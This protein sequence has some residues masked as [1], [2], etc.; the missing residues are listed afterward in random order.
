MGIAQFFVF[1]GHNQDFCPHPTVLRETKA[2]MW[3]FL[4]NLYPSCVWT[5]PNETSM[6]RKVLTIACIDG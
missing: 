4:H 3:S 1:Y 5:E 2:G 6:Y